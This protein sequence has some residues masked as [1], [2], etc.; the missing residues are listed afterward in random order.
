MILLIA[1]VRE[2]SDEGAAAGSIGITAAVGNATNTA[3]YA[4]VTDETGLEQS[5]D[6]AFQ[7]DSQTG[8]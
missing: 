5:T 6:P 2:R 1:T 8:S 7:I 3:T 4:L